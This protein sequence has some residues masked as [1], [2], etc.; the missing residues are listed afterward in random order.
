VRTRRWSR[1]RRLRPASKTTRG[2]GGGGLSPNVGDGR[3]H[4]SARLWGLLGRPISP[5]RTGHRMDSGLR[6][7]AWSS[8]VA[9][10]RAGRPALPCG[11][12]PSFSAP[13]ANLGSRSP[14]GA[15]R[16][17]AAH[18]KR[19]TLTR[20]APRNETRS[21]IRRVGCH[22][23]HRRPRRLGTLQWRGASAPSTRN[24]IRVVS[25]GAVGSAAVRPRIRSRSR[26]PARPAGR[27]RRRRC[28]PAGGAG[29]AGAGV[30]AAVAQLAGARLLG[31]GP[32]GFGADGFPADP[33]SSRGG[34]VVSGRGVGLGALP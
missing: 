34:A 31:D 23:Q 2:G 27:R 8:L 10:E 30:A 6:L 3:R 20:R 28:H 4:V 7:K 26:R 9:R 11:Q 18:R 12:E 14:R 33:I 29:D 1:L 25:P 32:A 13:V 16:V 5:R 22:R 19:I 21:E 17:M 15:R 24:S